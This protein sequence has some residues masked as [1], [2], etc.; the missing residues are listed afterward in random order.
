MFI[1]INTKPFNLFVQVFFYKEKFRSNNL[2]KYRRPKYTEKDVEYCILMG[3]FQQTFVETTNDI[4]MYV[5][6]IRFEQTNQH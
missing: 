4:I 1:E 3:F 6:N 5:L 2:K